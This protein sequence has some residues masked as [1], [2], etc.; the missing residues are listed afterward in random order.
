MQNLLENLHGQLRCDCPTC[1]KLIERVGKGHPDAAMR[2]MKSIVYNIGKEG[3]TMILDK[4][5]STQMP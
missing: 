4:I 1:N 5:H 2:S 3:R